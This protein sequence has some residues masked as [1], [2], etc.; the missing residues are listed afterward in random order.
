MSKPFAEALA[1]LAKSVAA[2]GSAPDTFADR[3]QQGDFMLFTTPGSLPSTAAANVD[4]EIVAT[5][6]L[7]VT[8]PDEG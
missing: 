1:E 8:V 7:V 4:V 3:E 5:E 6:P 2:I